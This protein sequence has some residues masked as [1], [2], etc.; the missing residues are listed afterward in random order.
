M[1]MSNNQQKSILITGCSKGIGS[2]AAKEL[3]SRGYR[4]FATVRKTTDI[5][6]L[7]AEGFEVE[8]MDLTDISSIDKALDNILKKT[9]GELD[10]LI[11]NAGY[12]VAGPVE[13][14]SLSLMRE[15]FETNFFGTFYLTKKV[16][17]IMRRQMHGRIVFISSINGFIANPFVGAYTASKFALEGLVEALAMELHASPINVSI[18]QPGIIATDFRRS[19]L[20]FSPPLESSSHFAT[21]KS[22]LAR[23]NTA[24]TEKEK[25]PFIKPPDAVVKKIIHALEAKKPKFHYRV[26]PLAHML[27]ILK[28]FLPDRILIKLISKFVS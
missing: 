24:S 9:Q 8:Q 5:V 11:N 4:V 2:C 19:S 23:I 3:K 7:Q 28:K 21:Y 15:Q 14:I 17:A 18:I 16:L 22:W 12:L 6:Q 13:D 27:Y 10:F 26:T 1:N 25:L 20:L